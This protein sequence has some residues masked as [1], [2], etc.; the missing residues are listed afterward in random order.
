MASGFYFDAGTLSYD[1]A[2]SSEVFDTEDEALR[3]GFPDETE[4]MDLAAEL[5]GAATDA[6]LNQ[7]LTRIIHKSANAAGKVMRSQTATALGGIL[8]GAVKQALPAIGSGI[9]VAVAGYRGAGIGEQSATRAGRIFGLE[10]EG[11]SPE[12]QEFEAARRFVRFAGAAVKNAALA[13]PGKPP[14]RAATEAAIS[15]ARQLAPGLVRKAE[16][17]AFR[18]AAI[19]PASGRWYRQ[20]GSIVVEYAS[21]I[22]H[23][24]PFGGPYHA[25]HRQY[26]QRI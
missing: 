7:T 12:D 16:G 19:R 5:L 13:P 3:A 1:D 20:G 11:L 10:L 8:K 9:G 24:N 23:L 25:R 6:Q 15:A 4:E 17:G 21:D 26:Q 2:M 14:V 22:N 18:P